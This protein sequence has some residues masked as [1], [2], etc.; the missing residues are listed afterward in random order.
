MDPDHP[1]IDESI[2]KKFDWVD[3]YIAAEESFLPYMP[4]PRGN[5]MSMNCFVDANHAADKVTKR[6]QTG[7]LLFCNK[8]PVIWHRKRQNGT[9]FCTFS[10]EFIVLKNA[11]ELIKA[12]RYKLR[13]FGVPIEGYT[14]GNVTTFYSLE[15]KKNV[16][17]PL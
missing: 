11:V 10:S 4:E 2:F 5:G 7:I 9:E 13:M 15:L 16:Q 17:K 8:A 1:H 12:L 3:F 6:S 14:N